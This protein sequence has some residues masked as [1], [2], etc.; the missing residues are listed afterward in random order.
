MEPSRTSLDRRV[1]RGVVQ[2]GDE[3]GRMLGV[4]TA[5]LRDVGLDLG[6]GVYAAVAD[7]GA[8]HSCRKLA[9]VSIGSRP[10]FYAGD[11][12]RLLEAHL[13]DFDGDL[14]GVTMQVELSEFLRPQRRFGS[15]ES[16]V[17]QLRKDVT[18]VV[19]WA[20]E[21]GHRGLVREEGDRS[22][23]RGRWGLI[24]ER[25]PEDRSKRSIQLLRRTERIA[26]A[27]RAAPPGRLTYSWV[28]E[29]TGLP[30]GYIVNAF[31]NIERLK[32]LGDATPVK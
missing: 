23:S 15:A 12:L 6:D 5:N 27:V 7:L 20:L 29:R 1:V 2:H 26:E 24:Q 28:S 14:Y 3:R 32:S 10:T 25:Q 11:A 19:A 30:E 17:R 21:S 9:V 18:D 4:P 8:P 16:L 22:R 13:L 31:P